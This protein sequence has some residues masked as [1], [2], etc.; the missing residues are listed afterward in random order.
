M[1]KQVLDSL[2]L[3]SD[4]ALVSK[5]QAK[6]HM[7]ELQDLGI[8]LVKLRPDQ[9]AKFGLSDSLFDAIIL[10]GK[11]NSNGALRRQYQYIG[12]LMRSVD[13][14]MVKAK[15]NEITG[16]SAFATRLLHLGEKWRERLLADDHELNNFIAEYPKIDI[17]QLRSLIRTVRKEIE[18]GQNRNYRKLYQFIRETL[19]GTN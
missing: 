10:A 16:D 19:G 6:K 15:L 18:H 4:E 13:E 9:L 3:L 5:T 1:K 7:E 11:I 12:K 14:D 17:S 2:D 8:A